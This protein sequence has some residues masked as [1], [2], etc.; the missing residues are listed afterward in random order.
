[1]KTS[2]PTGPTR[3]H[4]EPRV[5]IRILQR[6]QQHREVPGDRN[7]YGAPLTGGARHPVP[8]LGDMAI[9]RLDHAGVVVDHLEAATAFF[10][11]RRM[12]LEGQAPVEGR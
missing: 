3:A 7:P 5:G 10:A 1:M 2:S 6:R 12:K 4:C 11:E 9:Q 8:M